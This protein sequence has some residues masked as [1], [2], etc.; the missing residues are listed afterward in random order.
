MTPFKIKV[1]IDH[2]EQMGY[3]LK[4]GDTIYTKI[5]DGNFTIYGELITFDTKT[6]CWVGKNAT[7]KSFSITKVG[8]YIEI[9]VVPFEQYLN[10]MRQKSFG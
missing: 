9:M 8:H 4:T 6:N 1:S 10:K 7:L 3:A 5:K 2:Y